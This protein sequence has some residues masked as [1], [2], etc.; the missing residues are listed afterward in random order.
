VAFRPC[1]AKALR[2]GKHAGMEWPRFIVLLGV[3]V[4]MAISGF[5]YVFVLIFAAHR[6]VELVLGRPGEN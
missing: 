2:E 6:L 5:F 1:F 4:L 3:E